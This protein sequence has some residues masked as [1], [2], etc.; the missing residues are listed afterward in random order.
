MT[1][2]DL[3]LTFLPFAH[4][5]KAVGPVTRAVSGCGRQ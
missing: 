3:Y 5:E 2:S 1:V 4:T